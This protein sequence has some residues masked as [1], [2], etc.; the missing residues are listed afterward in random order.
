MGFFGGGTKV[1]CSRC[2]KDTKQNEDD[3]WDADIGDDNHRQW[4]EKH[5]CWLYRRI[6]Y[7][8]CKKC[9]SKNNKESWH[10]G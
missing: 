10:V 9:G 6:T 5:K 8:S 2:G 3:Y 1:Y 7:Y 4:N